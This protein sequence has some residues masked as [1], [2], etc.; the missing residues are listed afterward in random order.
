[1]LSDG[2]VIDEIDHQFW[3][4]ICSDSDLLA[5]E[6]AAIIADAERPVPP[7]RHDGRLASLWHGRADRTRRPSTSA[8]HSATRA[9]QRDAYDRPRQR[10]PPTLASGD[11]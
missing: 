6:F 7:N 8:G 2:E 1:M 11:A 5:G 9:G 3:V 4:L 10:S